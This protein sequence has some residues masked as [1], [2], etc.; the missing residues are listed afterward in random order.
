MQTAVL[1]PRL[2]VMQPPP[3]SWLTIDHRFPYPTKSGTESHLDL[4]ERFT[5]STH[6]IHQSN[7][8]LRFSTDFGYDKVQ[9][10]KDL[11]K[12]V[13]PLDHMWDHYL[14]TN[15]LLRAEYIKCD[16]LGTK[17]GSHV[18]SGRELV[19]ARLTPCCMTLAKTPTW[20]YLPA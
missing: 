1:E 12:D 6:G 19:A 18:P 11:G 7:Q 2:G 4:F 3:D 16:L 15:Q 5:N 9:M 14:L 13:H 10:L 17:P 20:R 8:P